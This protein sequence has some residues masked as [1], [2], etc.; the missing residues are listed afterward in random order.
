LGFCGFSSAFRRLTILSKSLLLTQTSGGEVGVE[1][2]FAF[3][4]STFD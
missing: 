2:A 4:S 3:S 1:P